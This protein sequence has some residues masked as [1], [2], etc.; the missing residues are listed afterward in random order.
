MGNTATR[1]KWICSDI[2]GYYIC[3]CGA[4]AIWNRDLQ[5]KEVLEP[6]PE[7]AYERRHPEN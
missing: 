7:E 6:I 5:K 1:H 3:R 4:T 2:P